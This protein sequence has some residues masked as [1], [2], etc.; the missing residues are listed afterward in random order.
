V[1]SSVT[2]GIG[3]TDTGLPYVLRLFKWLR[4][5]FPVTKAEQGVDPAT[6]QPILRDKHDLK[7]GAYPGV[8]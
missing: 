4:E 3:Q 6:G 8:K 7:N 5:T 2:A 1:G